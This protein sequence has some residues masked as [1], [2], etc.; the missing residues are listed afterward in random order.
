MKSLKIQ[1]FGGRGS[2]SGLGVGGPGIGFIDFINGV[3][4]VNDYPLPEGTNYP[5]FPDP[6][7]SNYNVSTSD[8][9]IKQTFNLM[10]YKRAEHD[11][12][13]EKYLRTLPINQKIQYDNKNDGSYVGYVE[14]LTDSNGIV[15]V[16][17]YNL[18]KADTRRMEYK[19][20][21]MFH[22]GYHACKDGLLDPGLKLS[23]PVA[24]FHEES[25]TEISAMFLA[26]KIN[27]YDYI[28][29]YT[30]EV[31]SAAAKYKRL[32]E[33]KHC[34]TIY[35]LGEVFYNERMN[36]RTNPSYATLEKRMKQ[37]NLN[38]NYYTKYY[39]RIIKNK[40][41]YLEICKN[42]LFNYEYF[43]QNYTGLYEKSFNAMIEKI[44]NNEELSPG[45]QKQ[46]FINCVAIS[47][48]DGGIL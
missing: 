24:R 21:T 30:L 12:T 33:Y 48:N 37:I 4:G 44:K 32:P 6:D 39:N 36:N 29:S 10:N 42:G 47:M 7:Y 28:P 23:R 15:R 17:K 2:R 25:R 27:G 11:I 46:Q 35:D 19:V 16:Y 45:L 20:K 43:N 3:A 13:G 38:D 40:D 9:F 1:L 5:D 14:S 18:N 34:K 8:K 41:R 26:H 22:E 31:I